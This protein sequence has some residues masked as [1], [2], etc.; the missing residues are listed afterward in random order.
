MNHTHFGVGVVRKCTC[1]LLAE[2]H[3]IVTWFIKFICRP[4]SHL[5]WSKTKSLIWNVVQ[6]TYTVA[7]RSELC[8]FQYC[9]PIRHVSAPA[10][11][12]DSLRPQIHSRKERV[13]GI[14]H[15]F[16]CSSSDV[17]RTS[18][19][20]LIRARKKSWKGRKKTLRPDIRL[21]DRWSTICLTFLLPNTYISMGSGPFT[22]L[23]EAIL[24]HKTR[25]MCGKICFNVLMEILA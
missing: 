11:V 5:N 16:T 25:N 6:C 4:E 7:R 2:Y 14:L 22:Y 20:G 8:N 9:P 24:D 10:R 3:I 21:H 23:Y 18:R 12:F 17:W 1:A 13:R 15:S 19:S